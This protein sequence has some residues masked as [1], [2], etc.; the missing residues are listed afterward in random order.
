MR[1]IDFYNDLKGHILY[2]GPYKKD[3]KDMIIPEG[4]AVKTKDGSLYFT[5]MLCRVERWYVCNGLVGDSSWGWHYHPLDKYKL[6]RLYYGI[7]V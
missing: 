2:W 5:N 4:E 7:D 1:E 3:P 6:L